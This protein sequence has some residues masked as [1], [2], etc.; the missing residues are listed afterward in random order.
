MTSSPSGTHT[1]LWRNAVVL[2]IGLLL[3]MAFGSGRD[4]AL[5]MLPFIAFCAI[6]GL[7]VSLKS[8]GTISAVIATVGLV[9][10]VSGLVGLCAWKSGTDIAAVGPVMAGLSPGSVLFAAVQST[11]DERR[12]ESAMLRALGARRRT[13]FAGVMAEFAALGAAA[14][15]L[16]SA[17]ASILAAV[18]AV[19]LFELPYEFNPLIWIAGVGAGIVVVCLSGFFAAR[20]A[21]NARPVDILRGAAT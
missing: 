17:G 14:G 19:Q 4:A 8:K 11:I 15:V 7:Q 2:V 6:I 18:V 12:F 3:H 1:L 21:I 20:G 13:V 16:A 10:V 9:G 5:V